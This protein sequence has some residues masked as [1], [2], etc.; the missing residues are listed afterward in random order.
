M[1][2]E[3]TS[4]LWILNLLPMNSFTFSFLV[5]LLH[6]YKSMYDALPHDLD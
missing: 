2:S 6:D 3:V 1:M 4:P 5:F